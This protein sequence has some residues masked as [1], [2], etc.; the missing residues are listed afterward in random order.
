M[1]RLLGVLAWIV[2]G[3]IF[4]IIAALWLVAWTGAAFGGARALSLCLRRPFTWTTV[5]LAAEEEWFWLSTFVIL[6]GWPVA[7]FG[8]MVGPGVVDFLAYCVRRLCR[9]S[10]TH[11]SKNVHPPQ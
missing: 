6:F 9:I 3:V 2:F 5:A 10:E 11:F 7:G 1:G 4:G 8:A